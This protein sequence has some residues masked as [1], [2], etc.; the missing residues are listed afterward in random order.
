MSIVAMAVCLVVGVVIGVLLGP[1]A[2]WRHDA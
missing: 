1:V 2:P